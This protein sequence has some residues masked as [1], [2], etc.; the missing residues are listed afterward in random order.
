MIADRQGL[1]TK[2]MLSVGIESMLIVLG[3]NVSVWLSYFPFK[4]F[5]INKCNILHSNV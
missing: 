4:Y 1:E 5:F 2:C 3:E